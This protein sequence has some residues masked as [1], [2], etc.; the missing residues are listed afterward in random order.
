MCSNADQWVASVEA[1]LSSW[2]RTQLAVSL[3][4]REEVTFY[5]GGFLPGNDCHDHGMRAGRDDG[6]KRDSLSIA[7]KCCHCLYRVSC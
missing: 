6:R 3:P 1:A 5:P 4:H 2:L 7:G